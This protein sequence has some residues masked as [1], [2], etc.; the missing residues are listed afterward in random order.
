MALTVAWI[1]IVKVAQIV[2][3]MGCNENECFQFGTFY[4]V[5]AENPMG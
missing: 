4:K 1:V 3:Q 5:N 2:N